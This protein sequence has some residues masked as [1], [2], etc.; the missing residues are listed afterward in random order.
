MAAAQAD[1]RCFGNA[2]EKRWLCEPSPFLVQLKSDGVDLKSF[3]AL[4]ARNGDETICSRE[5]DAGM[6]AACS[7]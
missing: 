3:G 7:A 6:V 1:C 2:G 4:E 5:N